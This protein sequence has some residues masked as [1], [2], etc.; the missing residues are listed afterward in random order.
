M[1]I[2]LSKLN[3]AEL[4][5]L[6]A[7]AQQALKDLEVRQREDARAAA[8]KAA[9]EYGFSLA[10]LTSGGR[11]KGKAAKAPAAAKYANPN[12]PSQT[13]SGRGRQPAWYKA[14]IDGG[15]STNELLISG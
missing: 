7:D 3:R 5:Q 8:E 12:D 6:Q 11:G 13:W 9:A 10:E 14:A 1:T 4:I 15:A 2:D